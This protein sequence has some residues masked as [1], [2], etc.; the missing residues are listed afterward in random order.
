[1]KAPAFSSLTSQTD[2]FI[3]LSGDYESNSVSHAYL[4]VSPDRLLLT[5]LSRMFAA[6]CITGDPIGE[7]GLIVQ[8]GVHADVKIYP[9]P[10]KQTVLTAD[11][12]D[13]I[14]SLYY[15]PTAGD[16]KFYIIDYGETMNAS[17]QN[18]LLK[19]LEE[20][21]QSVYIIINAADTSALLPTVVSRCKQIKPPPFT[22]RQLTES[23]EEEYPHSDKI[24]LAVSLSR[25]LLSYCEKAMTDGAYLKSF[26]NAL[27]VL[28]SL[29]N[30]KNILPC[31]SRIIGDKAEL[32]ETIGFFEI[33]FRDVMA[34]QAAGESAITCGALGE[35]IAVLA[36]EYSPGAVVE[37]MPA[38]WNAKKRLTLNGNPTSV[39]D[40][41]LFNIA[42]AKAKY[43]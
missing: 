38:V 39:A 26:D 25:G 3:K 29:K 34:Y 13:L 24:G 28:S 11:V 21:P 33:I 30:S 36:S 14:S 8:S 31:V 43:K 19:T 12:D 2:A 16:K 37:I 1:M 10:E 5:C 20:P 15:R 6:L 23:L 32:S 35:K 18:K 22:E 4:F 7:A 40:E 41:L 27:S 42:K 9:A 17:C